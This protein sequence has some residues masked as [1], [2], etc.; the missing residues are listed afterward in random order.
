MGK[1]Y[2]GTLKCVLSLLRAEQALRKESIVNLKANFQ[3]TT[4]SC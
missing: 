1:R 4:L 3:L 2:N